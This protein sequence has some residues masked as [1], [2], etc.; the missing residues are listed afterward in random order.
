MKTQVKTM[1]L[2]REGEMNMKNIC[3]NEASSKTELIMI[4][5]T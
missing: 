3:K 5:Q 4:T 1:V 2:Q